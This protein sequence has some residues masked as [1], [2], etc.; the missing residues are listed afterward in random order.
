MFWNKNGRYHP[1]PL[2]FCFPYLESS[3]LIFES[4]SFVFYPEFENQCTAATRMPILCVY[5]ICLL[6]CCR[7]RFLLASYYAID[8]QL[9]LVFIEIPI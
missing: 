4:S 5:I 3:S 6:L 8:V 2:V 9:L 7:C 1:H